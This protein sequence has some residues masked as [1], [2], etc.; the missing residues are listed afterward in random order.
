LNRPVTWLW[1][2]LPLTERMKDGLVWLLSPK[3]TVGVVGLVRD[4]EGR[5]LLLRHTY[6][7]SKPWGL[8]GG[9]LH[10]HESLE[11]CLR[12]EI[13]EEVGIEV[14]IDDLLMART[15]ARRRL[16]EMLFACHPAPGQTLDL[17]RPNPEVTEVRFFALEDF[18]QRE[19]PGQQYR[20]IVDNLK[21]ET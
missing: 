6:R 7:R 14:D 13:R 21:R 5:V 4:E 9:G 17:F 3:F 1:G 20:L 8:P 2:R 16:V 11:G 12:R 18:P 10:P 19:M 15:H